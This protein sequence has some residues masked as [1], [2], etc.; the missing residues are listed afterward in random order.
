MK[1]N[2]GRVLTTLEGERI[3]R[4]DNG[5]ATKNLLTVKTALVNL[6]S[7]RTTKGEEGIIEFGIAEKIA[8]FDI[9]DPDDKTKVNESAT[10]ELDE[11]AV[12]IVRKILNDEEEI[13]IVMRARLLD[14][15]KKPE[16]SPKNGDKGTA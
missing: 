8:L 7:S 2:I 3:T 10:M 12:Q 6:L 15:L 11:T 5:E 1:I 9:K 16:K 14:V 4:F 13:T